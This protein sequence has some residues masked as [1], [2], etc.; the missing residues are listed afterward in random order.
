VL[1]LAGPLDQIIAG[2]GYDR[3]WDQK[4][5]QPGIDVYEA[6]RAEGQRSRVANGKGGDQYD[7]FS[8]VFDL[9][10]KA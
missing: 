2:G 4:F 1:D 6:K 10:S 8:P 9:V 7:N 5:D 3:Q